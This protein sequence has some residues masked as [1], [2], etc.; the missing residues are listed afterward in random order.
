[1]HSPGGSRDTS[2]RAA[3]ATPENPESRIC[4]GAVVYGSVMG[5]FCCEDFGVGAL[6]NLRHR[7]IEDRYREFQDL[8]AH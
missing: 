4:D 6:R 3:I 1:M 7:R 2:P 8:T 5:S